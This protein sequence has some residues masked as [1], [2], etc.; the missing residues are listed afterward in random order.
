MALADWPPTWQRTDLVDAPRGE[1]VHVWAIQ[2]ARVKS[3]YDALY[4]LLS[5]D[6]QQR[7]G[8]FYF[9]HDR[10]TYVT[11]RGVLRRLLARYLAVE[12]TAIQFDY[13]KFD[14][15]FT[16]YPET[17]LQ[18]NVSHAGDVVLLAFGCE[19]PIGVDVELIRPIP[20]AANIVTRFFSPTEISTWR[21][22]P[23]EQKTTAFYTCWTR[24]EAYIKA[25]GEGLSH[26]LDQFDVTLRPDEPAALWTGESAESWS[27]AALPMPDSYVAAVVFGR[28]AI[29]IDHFLASN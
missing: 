6:E 18:F 15:P 26:P 1:Q 21:S 8:R 25:R 13:T 28:K 12:P 16:I 3:Q 5:I 23:D 4:A 29:Q 20:D 19:F 11:A 2:P 14:K 22:L 27:I 24:K 9:E 7:A 10:L 17:S